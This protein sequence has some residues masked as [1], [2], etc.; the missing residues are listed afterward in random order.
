MQKYHYILD[1]QNNMLPY[2]VYVMNGAYERQRFSN[3]GNKV[4]FTTKDK[5]AQEIDIPL[6][7]IKLIL[8]SPEWTKQI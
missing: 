3:D 2:Y 8:N 5:L 6:K 4:Y 1:V 7:E